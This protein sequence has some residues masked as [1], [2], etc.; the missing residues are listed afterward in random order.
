M[1]GVSCVSADACIAVG[2]TRSGA[3][4]NVTLA[5]RWNGEH[6]VVQAT[7][8]PAGALSADL[9]AV[10]CASA[11][12]CT[13]VG[14]YRDS[15]GTIATL[16]ERW[17]GRT[18]TIQAGPGPSGARESSLDGVSCTSATACVAVGDVT[19]D[20]SAG[21]TT[22]TLAETWNGTSWT[23]QAT[24]N[25][26][27]LST[28]QLIDV[29]CASPTA[30]TAVGDF[31]NFDLNDVTL[32]ERWDGTSW[33]IQATPN[34]AGAHTSYLNGVSCTADT[35][36]AVGDHTNGAGAEATL[37][38]RWDGTSWTIQATPNAA[39]ARRGP[40]NG[41]NGVSCTSADACT[42]VG[43]HT[44]PA[45]TPVT[46]A[47]RWNGRRWAIQTTP[48]PRGAQDTGLNGVSCASAHACLAVGSA[49]GRSGTEV[50]VAEHWNLTG[51]TIQAT[52]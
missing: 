32:A 48:N 25:P 14:E 41:F 18:W 37:A 22:A 33:T 2:D 38:E 36:T 39:T 19:S 16:A 1:Y 5:K 31:T 15:A 45:G 10:S 50:T 23:I 47:E 12:A 29:S 8:N 44:D 43:A 35:C 9:Y 28:A 6:W 20:G 21:A 4:A 17:D 3:R 30:C 13:A 34:P 11:D 27:D 46:L 51:W 42:A 7:P 24:P 52:A 40:T 49:H 26:P